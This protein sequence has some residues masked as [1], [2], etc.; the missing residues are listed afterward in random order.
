[1][2]GKHN[3]ASNKEEVA[4]RTCHMLKYRGTLRTEAKYK[5]VTRYVKLIQLYLIGHL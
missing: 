2:L 5:S 4:G 1:M 3:V